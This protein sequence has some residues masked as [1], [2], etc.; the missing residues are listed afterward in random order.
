MNRKKYTYEFIRVPFFK[1]TPVY[2]D[3][4]FYNGGD[5]YY[6]YRFFCFSVRVRD[7]SWVK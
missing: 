3:Q 5:I 4:I 2:W 6:G 7:K 1:G